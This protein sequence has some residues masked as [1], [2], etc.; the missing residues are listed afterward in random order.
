MKYLPPQAGGESKK[1]RRSRTGR[2][3]RFEREDRPQGLSP[4]FLRET[5][6]KPMVAEGRLLLRF[7]DRLN[8]PEQ[9]Y[10]SRRMDS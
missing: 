8:H 7:P 5:Y 2:P 3:L 9:V 4:A 1:I 10:C 6:L